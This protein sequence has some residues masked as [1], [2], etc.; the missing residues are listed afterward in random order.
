M[1]YESETNAW[2]FARPKDAVLYFDKAHIF[3]DRVLEG[4]DEVESL[5]Q[6]GGRFLDGVDD[7]LGIIPAPNIFL[8]NPIMTEVQEAGVK[9]FF[10]LT[11]SPL[12][13]M[14]VGL[15]NPLYP[16]AKSIFYA[17]LAVQARISGE[18][19][20]VIPSGSTH[21]DEGDEPCLTLTGLRL[22]DTS[23]MSWEHLFEF[24]KDEDSVRKL[25]N[26]RLFLSKEYRDAEPDR[27]RDDLQR[28]LE[29]HEAAARKW[30][31][32]LRDACLSMLLGKEVQLSAAAASGLLLAGR[33]HEAMAAGVPV[34]LQLG[35]V[36][37]EI[38]SRRRDYAFKADNDPVAY[39][40][41]LKKHT[42]A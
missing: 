9:E 41:D 13:E 19:R 29:E 10:R 33:Y 21:E 11:G 16:I 28:R 30:G 1:E 14:P 5:R 20:F 6:L 23:K 15:D 25:R 35:K 39:L 31:A 22:V 18:G 12:P 2:V 26:L 8:L 17:N 34:L 37:L 4:A 42:S 3:V 36:A 32:D 7:T 40:V 24:R 27:V 38:S